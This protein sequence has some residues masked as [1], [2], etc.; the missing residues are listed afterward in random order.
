MKVNSNI[1][2]IAIVDIKYANSRSLLLY[3]IDNKDNV[4]HFYD[5]YGGLAEKDA[6]DMFSLKYDKYVIPGINT[7]YATSS[8]SS[9]ILEVE[10]QTDVLIHKYHFLLHTAKK[11]VKE[12]AWSSD[13]KTVI[14]S[15]KNSPYVFQIILD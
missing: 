11:E 14:Y 9:E 3:V 12:E 8:S 13:K 1:K 10:K 6:R 4:Y 2:N 5:T 15:L 7:I